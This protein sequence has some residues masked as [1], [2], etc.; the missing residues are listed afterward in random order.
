MT[1]LG[2]NP[3]HENGKPVTNHLSYGTDQFNVLMNVWEDGSQSFACKLFK[4]HMFPF[5]CQFLL[6]QLKQTVG[7]A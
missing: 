1:C 3:G 4:N 7:A 5:T 2:T 6:N